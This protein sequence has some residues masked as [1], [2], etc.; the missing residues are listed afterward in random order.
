[1]LETLLTRLPVNLDFTIFIREIFIIFTLETDLR[2]SLE[3]IDLVGILKRGLQE[4]LDLI[5]LLG[6]L[7][8]CLQAALDFI[9]LIEIYQTSLQAT[10]HFKLNGDI[11][12]WF[13]GKGRSHEVTRDNINRFA[14]YK[15]VY[16]LVNYNFMNDF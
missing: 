6:T 15:R 2:A 8:T 7:L 12:K 3:F 14:S 4:T 10:L 16:I 11:K 5:G 1:M 9:G 13:T